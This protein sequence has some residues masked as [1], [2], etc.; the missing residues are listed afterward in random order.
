MAPFESLGKVF[1]SHALV[2]MALFCTISEIKRGIERKLRFFHTS[3][4]FDD[5]VRWFPSEYCHIV[6]YG[7][8]RML[9][10]QD[11]EKSLMICLTVSIE[12]RR[13]T[14]RQ[15]DRRTDKRTDIL[16]RHSPRYA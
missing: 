1:Y 3:R 16:Q 15:T 13:V 10:L 2:T 11:G 8:S 4:A 12:Y 7:N 9:W 5:P 14:D 6:W